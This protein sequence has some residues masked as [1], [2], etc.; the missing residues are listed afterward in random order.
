MRPGPYRVLPGSVASAQCVREL[1]LAAGQH[2]LIV[3]VLLRRSTGLA[4][5]TASP[6]QTG[7][8]SALAATSALGWIRSSRH[9]RKTFPGGRRT[10]G[11]PAARRSG[12]TPAATVASCGGAA[13]CAPPRSGSGRLPRTPRRRRPGSRMPTSWPAV[14]PRP[15]PSATWQVALSAGLVVGS[16]REGR[17]ARDSGRRRRLQL[18]KA[19]ACNSPV[20]C[21]VAMTGIWAEEHHHPSVSRLHEAGSRPFVSAGLGTW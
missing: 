18:G 16:C 10:P 13:T 20:S 5:R 19:Q 3:P 6:G 9:L 12:Q 7:L 8:T 17:G 21:H 14:R 2:K 15:A 4:C 11:S 1:A